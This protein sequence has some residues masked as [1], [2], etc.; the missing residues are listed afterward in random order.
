MNRELITLKPTVNRRLR[1]TIGG[2]RLNTGGFTIIELMMVL[3]IVGILASIAM[4]SY[5]QYLYRAEITQV[6]VDM[7]AIERKINLFEAETGLLPGSLE[8]VGASTLDPWGNPYQYLPIAESTSSS[9]SG[10]ESK[11]KGKDKGKGGGG[12]GKLRKDKNLVPINSDYDLYSMGEDGKS[13]SP[14]TAQS[15]RDDIIRANNGA[16]VGLASKY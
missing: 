8:E 5:A 3:G 12:V 2:K 9:S 15:S 16:F 4:V 11:G 13:V 7:G 10:T 6:I 1:H 14:L